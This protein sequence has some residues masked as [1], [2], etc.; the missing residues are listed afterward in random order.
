MMTTLPQPDS[1][2]IAL[3]AALSGLIRRRIAEAGGALRFD[4]YMQA[5]LYEPGLGYYVAGQRRFGPD[6]DFVTAPE[7]SPLF[8]RCLAVQ[9]ARWL[10]AGAPPVIWEFGAG[11]GALAAEVIAALTEGGRAPARYRIVEVSPDLRER[12]RSL[13]RER[14]PAQAFD[15]IE[16][17][18]E[19][20]ERLEGVVLANEVLDAMPVRLFEC[21]ENRIHDCEVV[22]R[23]DRFEWQLRLADPPFE[24]A[25]RA[26]L[27]ASGW[28]VG[29]FGS[30]YRSELGEQ[31]LAWVRSIG[32][33]LVR[34]AMLIID[35]G[36]PS[37][38]FFH[39][40]RRAGTLNCHYRH[41][42][43]DDPFWWPGLCDI[44]AHVDFSAVS[45]AALASGLE[46]LGYTSQ[47]HFLL[48]CGLA[49]HFSAR[50]PD[51]PLARARAAQ[52]IQQL[53]SEAEMG[54]L[55]KVIAFG[56]GLDDSVQ[57]G[58]AGRDRSAMLAA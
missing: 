55:F 5:A 45:E 20:P 48:G 8:G 21:L 26:R 57:K 18:D 44:T 15:R 29:V 19:L 42:A 2:Q 37:R 11:S 47:A 28:P 58:L 36:F 30:G 34:G 33:R 10:D 49:E 40:Q 39:P 46:L 32:E 9:L 12:Q 27:A 25:V 52:A 31:A 6:G 17:L 23:G 41:H 24:Q 50:V 16:W 43:H 13:L 54:E 53:V 4:H 14:L 22:A 56:R 51:E 38:E 7:L 1:D 3:S 35:Y